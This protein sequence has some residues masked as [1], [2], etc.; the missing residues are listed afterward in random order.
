MRCTILVG[1]LVL[2]VL[3]KENVCRKYSRLPIKHVAHNNFISGTGKGKRDKL[4]L[5]CLNSNRVFIVDTKNERKPE[6]F[7]TLESEDFFAQ[8]LKGEP[9][10]NTPH[11]THCLPNGSIMISTMGKG[12]DLRGSGQFV[13]LDSKFDVIGK[14]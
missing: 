1:I 5:P 14:I 4:I 13:L 9:A 8:K 10:Y 7:K 6:M 12:P 2:V 3:L 11:T